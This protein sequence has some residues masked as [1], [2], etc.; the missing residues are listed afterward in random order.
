M[1]A[2]LVLS[3]VVGALAKVGG[4]VRAPNHQNVMHMCKGA[5]NMTC[6]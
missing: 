3:P 6:K 1:Q 4:L 5:I 2:V